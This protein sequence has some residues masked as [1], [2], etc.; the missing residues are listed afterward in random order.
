MKNVKDIVVVALGVSMALD[1]A[2][3][4]DGKIDLND[5]GLLIPVG[6]KV[7]EAINDAKLAKDELMHATPEE[8]AAFNVQI[9]QEYNIADDEV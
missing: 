6:M 4:N 7:P 8:R 3:A 5:I 2:K 9:A 1:Q